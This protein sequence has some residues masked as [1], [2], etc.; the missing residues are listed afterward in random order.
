MT[1]KTNI[2]RSAVKMREEFSRTRLLV[3]V[4]G[5]IVL[6]LYGVSTTMAEEPAQRVA[7]TYQPAE[8]KAVVSPVSHMDALTAIF[9]RR[10]IRKYTSQPVSE[11]TVTT[12]LKAAMSAPSAR[13]EQPWEFIVVRDRNTL[14]QVTG[15][16][17]FALH[18]P[19]AQ[20][21]I[22]VLG[23]TRLEAHSGLWALDCANATMNIL[24]AA[25]SMGLGAVWTTLYPYE[26]RM[27]GARKLFNIPEKVIP[28][29]FVPIGHPAETKAQEDRFKPA[30]IHKEHW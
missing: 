6:V 18:V 22:V 7:T 8:I 16:H 20:V 26:D 19:D 30:R 28:L 12:L 27:A 11:E 25:H 21:A 10:S 3:T 23:D 4:M 29:A 13:N 17:P 15:F 1:T 24:L 9:T 14:K 5:V 2:G